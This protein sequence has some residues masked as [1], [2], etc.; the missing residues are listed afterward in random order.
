MEVL[1]SW[2]SAILCFWPRGAPGGYGGVFISDDDDDRE[3]VELMRTM[4]MREV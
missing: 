1:E 3:G 2:V 4:R